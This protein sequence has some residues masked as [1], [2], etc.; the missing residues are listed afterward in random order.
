MVW[1]L[2]ISRGC[3]R[4]RGGL[5]GEVPFEALVLNFLGHGE[6]W[7]AEGIPGDGSCFPSHGLCFLAPAPVLV[8]DSV[9]IL[10]SPP[11]DP[12]ISSG[13]PG[14]RV[15]TGIW[16]EKVPG[17][18]CRHHARGSPSGNQLAHGCSQLSWKQLLLKPQPRARGPARVWVEY[19]GKKALFSLFFRLDFSDLQ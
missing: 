2:L 11:A 3:G 1:F 9:S 4:A 5:L 15:P 7:G 8:Q 16:D 18:S 17:W 13:N 6:L 14:G 10:C 12:W 19:L